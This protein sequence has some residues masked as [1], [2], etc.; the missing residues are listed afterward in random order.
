MSEVNI[1]NLNSMIMIY[2]KHWGKNKPLISPPPPPELNMLIA[3]NAGMAA[4]SL[5]LTLI[6]GP[7]PKWL[8][9]PSQFWHKE[10]V[11]L[12]KTSQPQYVR[13]VHLPTVWQIYYHKF[14]ISWEI[15]LQMT[16]WQLCNHLR[17]PSHAI[18]S[19]TVLVINIRA[20][21][22][23]YTWWNILTNWQAEDQPVLQR[24][25]L[26]TYCTFQRDASTAFQHAEIS[27][28]SMANLPFNFFAI[29]YFHKAG[30]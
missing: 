9:H 10:P 18:P 12:S 13:K 19:Y 28:I 5:T 3:L 22:W 16:W 30:Y 26:L 1:D 29:R 4:H 25:M 6:I 21:K 2:K 7:L 17:S 8:T 14:K 24:L 20:M 27:I 23:L 15:L 11:F